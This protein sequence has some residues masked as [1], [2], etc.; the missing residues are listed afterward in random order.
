M[1]K[2]DYMDNKTIRELSTT[3]K[4]SKEAI[5]KKVNYTLKDEL[6]NHVIKQDKKTYITPEGQ[7]IIFQS[8]KKERQETHKQINNSESEVNNKKATSSTELNSAFDNQ[9]LDLLNTQVIN[10]TQQINN[11]IKEKKELIEINK[12]LVDTLNIKSR[13]DAGTLITNQH[14]LKTQVKEPFFKRIFKLY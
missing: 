8:L 7:N 1:I 10:L 9:I 13:I 5:Y 14:N 4:I 3:F 11:H 12:S 6:R 2:G